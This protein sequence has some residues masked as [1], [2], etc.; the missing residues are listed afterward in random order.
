MALHITKT[1]EIDMSKSSIGQYDRL[2]TTDGRM[3]IEY[4]KK[5][6]IITFRTGGESY[7]EVD[8]HDC[9]DAFEELGLTD[10]IH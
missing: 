3:K 5:L 9:L 7:I 4:D 6:G 10:L 1:V 2:E 8:A